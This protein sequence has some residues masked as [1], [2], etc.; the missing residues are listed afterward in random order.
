MVSYQHVKQ[1][2]SNSRSFND[3]WRHL[4]KQKVILVSLM[5][6]ILAYLPRAVSPFSVPKVPYQ[7]SPNGYD[8]S[9]LEGRGSLGTYQTNNF[10]HQQFK[11]F[12][13][14]FLLHPWL[15]LLILIIINFFSFIK[16]EIL[17]NSS[18]IL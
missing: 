4:K 5:S 17:A 11:N 16:F 18:D 6:M 9:G 7:A 14:M 13:V 2:C 12:Q 3:S 15:K 8:K 1:H 10:V